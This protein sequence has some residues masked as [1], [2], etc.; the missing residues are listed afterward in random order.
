MAAATAG[1]PSPFASP[2]VRRLA[3]EI[4]VD[5]IDVRGTGPGGRIGEEDVKRAAREVRR[6]AAPAAPASA[7]VPTGG[8]EAPPL[9][10]FTQFGDVEREPL[11]R[12]R[13]TVARNMAT[14]WAIIPHVTLHTLMR[15]H[16]F[17]WIMLAS[18]ILFVP[19]ETTASWLGVG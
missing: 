19:G 10:D 2:S 6:G 18:L 17:Q 3:R 12:F 13:R 11:T 16:L 9:P 4:G 8:I 15:M 14:S 5:L 1:A 7:S